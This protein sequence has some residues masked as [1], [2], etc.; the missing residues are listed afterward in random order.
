MRYHAEELRYERV[1]IFEKEA[2]FNC[3]RIQGASVPE[4]LYQYEVRHDDEG[5]GNPVQI[6]RGILVNFYGSL[7]FREKLEDIETQGTIY[8]SE[9]DW[10]W[11]SDRSIT[12]DELLRKE[13]EEPL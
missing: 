7:L 2:F 5:L 11:M 12:L 13:K 3:D 8:I 1:R 4:G 6:A 9:A 10:H